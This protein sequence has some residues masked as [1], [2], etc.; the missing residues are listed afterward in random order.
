MEVRRLTI[1]RARKL[2]ARGDLTPVD[3]AEDIARAVEERDGDIGAYLEF[4]RDDLL[5]RARAMTATGAWRSQPLGGIPIAIKDNIC[6]AGRRT[7]CGSRILQHW[8]SPYSA[9]VVEKLE[10]AGAI[11]CGKT[12]CDEFAMGSSGEN[13]AFGTVKNPWDTDRVPGGSSAGSA[14]AVAAEL[15]LGAL[16]SDTGGSIRQPA[17]FCGVVGLKPTYGRVSRYGLVAFASSLDQV[18][19]VTKSVKDAALVL[20]VIAGKD[21]RDSTS[22]S[23]P[24]DDYSDQLDGGLEGLVVGVPRGFIDAEMSREVRSGF[25]AL[26]VRLVAAGVRVRDVDFPHASHA[27]AAYHV[28]ANAEASANLARFDGVGYGHRAQKALDLR[29]M[30]TGRAARGSVPRS[31]GGSS[32][33]PTCSAPGTATRTTSRP[34]R[35]ARSSCAA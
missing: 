27:V 13:S 4:Y 17:G 28:I 16:G 24:V 11:I 18:G 22:V 7:T 34:R 19:P 3:I 20:G 12:N 15:A 6:V 2:L 10:A 14:A 21:R 31:S 1:T 8:K 29:E 35:S 23:A 26:V 30:V 32:W 9:T 25:D 5:A 33:G